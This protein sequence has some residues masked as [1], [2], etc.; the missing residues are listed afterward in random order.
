MANAEKNSKLQKNH[1]ILVSDEIFRPVLNRPSELE[2]DFE[3]R[4]PSFVVRNRISGR[5]SFRT[6]STERSRHQAG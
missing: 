4:C 2:D 6:E 5:V 3:A 1:Q